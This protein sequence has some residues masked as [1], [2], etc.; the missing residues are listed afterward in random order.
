MLQC[1]IRI[2]L[3][4]PTKALISWTK[5]ADIVGAIKKERIF[6]VNFNIDEEK[7]KTEVNENL[8][9]Y[10]EDV[11]SGITSPK[12]VIVKINEILQKDFENCKV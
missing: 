1:L 11:I 12:D 7:Q 8:N 10:V 3:N 6:R 4:L 5:D 9:I 2:E